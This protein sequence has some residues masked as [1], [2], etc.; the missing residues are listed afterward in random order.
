M[1]EKEISRESEPEPEPENVLSK[2]E[3][4]N[5][6]SFEDLYALLRAKG[7]KSTQT[8]LHGQGRHVNEDPYKTEERS[9]E[10]YIE[11]IEEFRNDKKRRDPSSSIHFRGWQLDQPLESTIERLL[12][13]DVE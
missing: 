11:K 5:V 13:E 12:G 6:K 8:F 10:D 7:Y 2:E 9:T 3:L 4:D 1:G